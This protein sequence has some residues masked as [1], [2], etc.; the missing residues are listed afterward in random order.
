MGEQNDEQS[1]E[2]GGNRISTA[3]AVAVI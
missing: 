3:F 1:I 2:D